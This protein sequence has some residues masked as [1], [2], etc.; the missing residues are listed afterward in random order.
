MMAHTF[1]LGSVVISKAGRDSGKY[2]VVVKAEEE[3]YVY[4]ADG[5]LRRLAKPKRKK[6]KHIAQTPHI[7]T[8]I[9]E[10]LAE[11]KKV[12][13][14]EIRSALKNIVEAGTGDERPQKS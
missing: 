3:D 11:G 7:L 2:F 13:D 1:R 4:L 14:A 5:S 9:E 12:F 10:K 6:A 8:G